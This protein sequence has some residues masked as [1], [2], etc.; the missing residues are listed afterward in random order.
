MPNKSI[1]GKH[2]REPGTTSNTKSETAEPDSL[3]ALDNNNLGYR[4]VKDGSQ[5]GTGYGP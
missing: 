1:N 4:I 3:L 5:S 2:R